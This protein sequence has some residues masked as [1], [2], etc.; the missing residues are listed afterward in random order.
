MRANKTVVGSIDV[1]PSEAG[2][3]EGAWS[4]LGGLVV[5]VGEWSA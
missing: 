1:G 2:G 3:C 4:E 5:L